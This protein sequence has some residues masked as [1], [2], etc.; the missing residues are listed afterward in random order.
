[1]ACLIVTRTLPAFL[2]SEAPANV[3]R[4]TL[5]FAERVAY[6][7][8]IED[9]YWRHR[10]WPKERPDPK[11]S[12]DAVMS[13]AAIEKKVQN[14]LRDSE[15][16]EEEW[17][18]PITPEQLQAEMKRMAQ[19][20][21][22]PE[23]LRELFAALEAVVGATTILASNT[24]SLTVADIAAACRRP[25]RVAGLHFFNPVPLMKVAEVIAAVRTAPATVATLAALVEGA[26]HRAVVTADQPGFL[27]NHAG[28]GL[29]TEGLAILEE[30]VASA[31]EIGPSG[32]PVSAIRPSV[33]PSNQSNLMNGAWLSG[34]SR[35]AREFS[36]IRLR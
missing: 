27:V 36:R 11:P 23:V 33:S 17:Q 4:R 30:Q 26:G 20:S 6:Q 21:K 25:E 13:Q 31:S 10:I 24:S 5:T 29:Y 15:L 8:A 22:Q 2:Q 19:H 28:R 16:L 12:L 3:S 32:P 7:H 34:D 9:V 18:K 1:M 14:Y 35:N